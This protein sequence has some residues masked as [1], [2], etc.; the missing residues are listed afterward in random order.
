M[1]N[2]DSYYPVA[3]KLLNACDKARMTPF[4]PVNGFSAFLQCYMSLLLLW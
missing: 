3:Q 4:V 2:V 1:Q